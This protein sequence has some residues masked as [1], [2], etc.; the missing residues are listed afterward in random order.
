MQYEIYV[1]SQQQQDVSKVQFSGF[2]YL[3]CS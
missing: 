1:S 2:M 3:V